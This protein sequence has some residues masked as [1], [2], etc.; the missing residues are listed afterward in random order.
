MC[1]TAYMGRDK[2]EIL[3]RGVS[4][5]SNTLTIGGIPGLDLDLL[6]DKFKNILK[7]TEKEE[8]FEAF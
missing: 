6:S 4:A 8:L 7:E 1:N 3:I 5:Q 2:M